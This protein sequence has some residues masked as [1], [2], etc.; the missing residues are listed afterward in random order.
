MNSLVILLGPTGV[1][2]TE[3][4]LRIAEHFGSPIISSDS[5]QLYKDLPIGTAAPTPEQMARVKHYMVG[6]LDLTDYYSASN[7][8][9]DVISLLNT[10]HQ[11][12]PT[13]VMTGGSMMYIDAVCKGI[14][15]IPT[16]TPEI[17]EAIYTQFECEGLEPILAELKEADPIHYDEVDR[18]NYKRVIHAVEICRMTGKPYSSFRT[19]IKK[20]RPFKIIKI[21]LTRNR[22]ELCDRINRRVDQMMAD[23]LLEEARKVYPYRHLNSLNTVGYKELFNYFDGEWS[24][25]F[26]VEKIRRNSRV[27]ARKQMTWFKRDEEIEWFHPEDETEILNSI[28]KKL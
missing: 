6:T 20:E 10:L 18:M 13:V 2:K 21:G 12:T 24:L 26:A 14:D 9:E 1:G 7:F 27:Y 3:L 8:E 15:D 11:T 25:D 23:G 28:E 16:V 22:D 4:S 5:R 17:R 19:N